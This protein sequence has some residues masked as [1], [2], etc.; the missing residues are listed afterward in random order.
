MTGRS[1][2]VKERSG[3]EREREFKR[4][5]KNK[6]DQRGRGSLRDERE[7]EICSH[8]NFSRS[9][10]VTCMRGTYIIFG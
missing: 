6:R 4:K 2:I 5:T 1:D 3:R 9:C 8:N 7:R 10:L